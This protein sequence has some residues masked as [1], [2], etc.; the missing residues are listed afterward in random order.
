MKVYYCK[1]STGVRPPQFK[2]HDVKDAITEAKRRAQEHKC[3]VEILKVIGTVKWK[4]VPVTE[5]KPVL[6]MSDGEKIEDE[7]PF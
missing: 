1:T 6:E 3:E 7:L 2:H 4:P 5:M